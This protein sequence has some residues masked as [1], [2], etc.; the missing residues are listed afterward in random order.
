MPGSGRTSSSP[1]TPKGISASDADSPVAGM[2]HM[3][4]RTAPKSPGKADPV[5]ALATLTKG[6]RGKLKCKTEIVKENPWQCACPLKDMM[7]TK[8]EQCVEN[9]VYC[10]NN[11]K[12]QVE[13][14]KEHFHV[15]DKTEYFKC[16]CGNPLTRSSNERNKTLV[17]AG[18]T[19]RTLQDVCKENKALREQNQ[20]LTGIDTRSYPPG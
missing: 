11:Q 10:Y 9:L 8:A 13:F 12:S 4:T 20:R 18:C 2:S 15:T 19:Y 1:Q 5:Y 7:H 6:K 14:L 3:N 16:H 17:C